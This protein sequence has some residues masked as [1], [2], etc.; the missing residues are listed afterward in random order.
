MNFSIAK[1][2]HYDCRLLC[3]MTIWAAGVSDRPE[4]AIFS[5]KVRACPLEQRIGHLAEGKSSARGARGATRSCKK[6]VSRGQHTLSRGASSCE[7]LDRM[8]H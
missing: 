5:R 6:K 3:S 7:R 1:R 2:M 8:F 4:I